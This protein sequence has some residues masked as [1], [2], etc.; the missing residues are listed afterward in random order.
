MHMPCKWI[1]PI[2]NQYID[3]ELNP[4][5]SILVSRHIKSCPE[6]NTELEK[7]TAARAVIQ[8]I[9]AHI[10]APSYL[11]HSI[12]HKIALSEH[13]S[14]CRPSM[15]RWILKPE[16][17]WGFATVFILTM[18]IS[19][20]FVIKPDVSACNSITTIQIDYQK[21][22]SVSDV[23]SVLNYF[24]KGNMLQPVNLTIQNND[25]RSGDAVVLHM[26]IKKD[27]KILVYTHGNSA[28]IKSVESGEVKLKRI[29]IDGKD[30]YVGNFM[31]MK[32]ICWK[33]DGQPFALVIEGAGHER[34]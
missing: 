9:Q 27:N 18:L 24:G 1:K 5:K 13:L 25:C 11:R 2:L 8:N 31:D 7:L 17:S 32:V 3:G 14:E 33:L 15:I 19:Y 23:S 29:G 30:F 6:C 28:D 20:L 16:F 22:P 34:A 10:E 12:K 26:A 21:Q 4:A